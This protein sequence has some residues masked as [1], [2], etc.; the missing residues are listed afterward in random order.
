MLNPKLVL[1]KRLVLI[2]NFCI[3]CVNIIAFGKLNPISLTIILCIIF[4]NLLDLFFYFYKI[5]YQ[6]SNLLFMNKIIDCF[7]FFNELDLLEIR[8]KYLYDAVDY[9]VIVEADT[10]FNGDSKPLIF[11][12]NS[13]R[14]APFVDKIVYVPIKIKKFEQ[15]TKVAWKREVYQRDC[16][17][18][19]M[20]KLQLNDSDIVLISDIDE[21]PK[22][23]ILFDLKNNS[24]KNIPNVSKKSNF[25]L[26]MNVLFYAVKSVFYKVINKDIWKLKSQ[27]K[28]IYFILFKNFPT[29]YSF[30]M[31]NNYYF[32]NYKKKNS[33]WPGLQC[34]KAIWIKKF[35]PNEIRA[36]RVNPI[37]IIKDSGWHFSFLGGKEMIKYKIKNFSHQE[38]NIPEIVSDDYIEFC[39]QNGYSLF[40][41]YKNP[42]AK[43]KYEK[44][45][46]S[47]LPLDL[48]NIVIK[49]KNLIVE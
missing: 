2:I 5:V 33:Y 23:E 16:I 38:Y 7:T 13:L 40:E 46:L 26:L 48:R 35:T 15:T 19:G 22:K 21:I 8:L 11:K 36:F 10:S 43:P 37:Q 24:V 39:I 20:M 18:Q 49:Y 28:L 30:E 47:Y 27:L 12:E 4:T 14:F 6:H 32:L 42:S 41:Y 31:N 25:A 17:K 1:C 9:F 29:P 34:V 45:D 3:Y 44:L